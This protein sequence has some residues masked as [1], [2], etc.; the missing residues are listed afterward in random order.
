MN[1][2]TVIGFLDES[3]PQTTANTVRLWSFTKPVIFKNTTKL[4][5]NSFGF[6]ALNGSSV[7]DFKERST[8]EDVCD[9]LSTIKNSNLGKKIII[10]LDNFRSHRAK[11]TLSFAAAHD[12][13]LVYLPAYSPDLNPIE[14]IWKTIKRVISCNF[15]KDIVHMK[16]MIAE[17]FMMHSAK[18]SFAKSWIEKFLTD[19]S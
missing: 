10:V 2:D 3:S 6:Y 12:I 17:T 7:I 19:K 18:L 9:F 15:V 4:R 13:E 16:N 14:F 1:N 11:D 5:A 8:K